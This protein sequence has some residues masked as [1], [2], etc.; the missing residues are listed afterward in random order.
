MNR[1]KWEFKFSPTELHAAAIQQRDF[2]LSRVKAWTEAKEKVMAEV[3]G[4][5]IEV[6]ESA[7]ANNSYTTNQ[8]G[9]RVMVRA[10]LQ[11]K[12]T[13]CHAKIQEHSKAASEYSAWVR[14]FA[15][16]V[17]DAE[18]TY[19]DYVYFFGQRVSEAQ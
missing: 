3:R 13:E 11:A 9:P 14:L 16:R 8:M 19:D 5:G 12:L 17:R 1:D 18:L 6:S 10:D 7:I 15:A 4:S 2:R